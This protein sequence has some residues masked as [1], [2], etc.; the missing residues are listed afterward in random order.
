MGIYNYWI[1]L[2][3]TIRFLHLSLNL[4][5]NVDEKGHTLVYMWKHYGRVHYIGK[6][7]WDRPLKHT[8][9]TLSRVLDP[10]WELIIVAENL[11]DAQACVLEA[12]L[13]RMAKKT[14][15]LSVRGSYEWDG[16]SLI[17]KVTP[18]TYRGI[19]FEDMFEQYLNLN[20]RNWE[21]LEREINN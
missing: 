16:V 3:F 2:G 5:K 4:F 9:D 8:K 7:L 15:R 14:R 13:I 18:I 10:S 11:T 19:L 12:K 1:E 20:D 21:Q 17:N 6:G